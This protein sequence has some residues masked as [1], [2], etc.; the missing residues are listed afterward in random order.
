M[1][2]ARKTCR[3]A[4]VIDAGLS[5]KS[6]S[7]RTAMVVVGVLLIGAG[8]AAF[9]ATPATPRNSAT[10]DQAGR[11]SGA[12][13]PSVLRT[14]RLPD[15]PR[16]MLL[17]G[18]TLW[19]AIRGGRAGAPGRLFRL[20]ARTGRVRGRF[21]LPFDPLRLV[22]GFGSLWLTGQGGDRRYGGVLRVDPRSG[23]VVSVVR[24]RAGLG[25]AL[26]AS[27]NAIWVGGPDR[28]PKGHE[29]RSGV[30]GV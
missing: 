27:R 3:F 10:A 24:W 18:H 7:V 1:A 13:A 25:T 4:T 16:A 28:Y 19:V 6:R 15:K 29:E 8:I 26:A 9:S 14:V 11:C 22:S 30:Y 2:L 21:H 23:R 5:A 12:V 20:D 17:V